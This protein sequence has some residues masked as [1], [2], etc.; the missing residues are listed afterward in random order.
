[1][2]AGRR[3]AHLRLGTLVLGSGLGLLVGSGEGSSENSGACDEGC[4][5]ELVRLLH[6]ES[7]LE[8]HQCQAISFIVVTEHTMMGSWPVAGSADRLDKESRCKASSSER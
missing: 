7:V 1:V 4:D 2:A 8:L 5:H 6:H 3:V